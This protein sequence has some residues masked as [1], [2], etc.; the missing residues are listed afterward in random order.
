MGKSLTDSQ[1]LAMK[2]VVGSFANE[3]L[4]AMFFRGT[5]PIDRDHI[6]NPI[7]AYTSCCVQT[8]Y[9]KTTFTRSLIVE[10][11]WKISGHSY[12]DDEKTS[13]QRGRND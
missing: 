11:F 1:G 13:S 4:G 9:V 10:W 8:S 6:D 12:S 2:E 3:P 7:S 5:K